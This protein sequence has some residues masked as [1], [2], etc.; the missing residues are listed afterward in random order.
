[1]AKPS[2]ETNLV[3]RALFTFEALYVSRSST[4][5]NEAV[6]QAFSGGSR[7]PPGA[8]EGIN[9]VR[10][11]TNELDS[12]R[13][14]PLLVR[15]VAKNAAASVENVATKADGLVRAFLLQRWRSRLVWQIV[16][17]R[18]AVSLLGPLATPQ[19]VLNGQVATCLYHCWTKLD[20]L[21]E[22]HAESVSTVIGPSITVRARRVRDRRRTHVD[23]QKI[24]RR[25]DLIADPLLTA[26]KKELAGIVS[27]LHRLDLKKAMD[28]KSG[29]SGTSL[30]MK[31]LVDKLHFVKTGLLSHFAPESV[32]P[33][34]VVWV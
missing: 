18:S 6:A 14:D 30:Y 25:Y 28:P 27:R 16:S 34:C 1:M 9:I 12:A 8:N 22:E 4:R 3:L 15:A 5:M 33:W 2:P 19:Q 17:D 29:I 21:M 7:A 31:D 32:R 23:G 24:R 11:V 20:K 13:F 10:A 26:I